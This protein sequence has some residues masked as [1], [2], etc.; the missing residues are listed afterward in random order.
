MLTD[1]G[2]EFD[3]GTLL[4]WPDDDAR[5]QC[6]DILGNSM[7]HRDIT[8]NNYPEWGK[9][10]VETDTEKRKRKYL[11]NNGMLCLYCESDD[12]SSDNVLWD[13]PFT[14]V[15]KCDNCGK[16]WTDVY[17]LINVVED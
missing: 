17:K 15:V 3:D 16:R 12:I 10:F 13:D 14:V 6:L 5:I 8:D 4:L 1:I 9:L 11:E 2:Y 7:G